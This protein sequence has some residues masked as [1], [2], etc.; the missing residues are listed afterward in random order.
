MESFVASRARPVVLFGFLA[1]ATLSAELALVSSRQFPVHPGLFTSAAT[2][3]LVVAL[4]AA[5]WLLVVR[6]GI[7]SKR[8]ILRAA[9]IGVVVCALLF[10][11]RMRVLAIPIELLLLVVAFRAGRAAMK[12]GGDS[13]RLLSPE[14]P[15]ETRVSSCAFESKHG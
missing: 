14:A 8:S 9:C 3:D 10:G 1:A 5:W 12:A 4:P 6:P 7:A 2:F 11:A 13:R 15:A